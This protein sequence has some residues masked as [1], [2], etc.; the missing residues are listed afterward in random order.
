VATSL[1]AQLVIP[2]DPGATFAL[3]TDPGYVEEVAA[4]T[5]GSDTE[6]SVT[7]GDDGSATV[8]SARTLPAD[9]PSYAKA[10]VGE[11]LRLTETRVFGPADADGT[12]EG[13]VT[14]G[15]DGAPVTVTG[16]LRLVA[17]GEVTDVDVAMSVKASVP[18]VGGKIEKFAADEIH[19]FLDKEQ[20]IAS[21]RL[22]K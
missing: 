1:S 8:V 3:M 22:Q 4:G 9:L 21:A 13:T 10:L 14:V 7:L 2:A 17:A 18:F 5:G 11:H 19:K 15:F 16:T 6:V 20:Q 12:R